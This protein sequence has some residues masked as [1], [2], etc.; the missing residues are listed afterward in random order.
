[1]AMVLRNA[2]APRSAVKLTCHALPQR[3][4]ALAQFS[5][6]ST[7][8]TVANA[9]D[10]IDSRQLVLMQAKRLAD[11]PSNSIALDTTARNSNCHRQADARYAH[12]VGSRRHTKE[13]IAETAPFGISRIKVRLAAQALPRGKRQLLGGRR[14]VASRAPAQSVGPPIERL[15]NE[16]SAALGAT[17]GE[18]GATILR[19]HAGPETV[20]A[21]TPHFARLIGALHS[22]A[23]SMV[24]GFSKGRQG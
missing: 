13:S 9:D 6:G 20:R 4:Q 11:Y 21:S 15:R 23:P 24:R 8:R 16:L 18:N 1:M 5:P 7:S 3:A 10:Q 22:M 12:F 17:A 14:G 19:S 2:S